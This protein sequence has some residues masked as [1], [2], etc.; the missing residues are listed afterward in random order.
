MENF[1]KIIKAKDKEI[2]KFFE[3]KDMRKLEEMKAKLEEEHQE[4][5]EHLKEVDY[6]L[7]LIAHHQ[8]ES[9]T[10]TEK[11]GKKR[12][13]WLDKIKTAFEDANQKTINDLSTEEISFLEKE[14]S[15]LLFEKELLEKEHYHIHQLI[16]KT[17]VFL[18]DAQNDVCKEITKKYD[19]AAVGEKLVEHF[20]KELDGEIDYESGRAKIR[21]MLEKTF[22]INKLQSKE[23]FDLLEKTKVIS[24]N[25]DYSNLLVIPNYDDF[26]QYTDTSYVPLFGNWK[27][28][29]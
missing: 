9:T 19:I 4:I 29:A 5:K 18:M 8:I 27:I 12:K 25:I 6:L 21:K 7:D 28:N 15:K 3:K 22:S 24:F 11:Q 2:S 26:D 13:T 16:A 14:K 1:I 20:G 17:E 23:L 10:T